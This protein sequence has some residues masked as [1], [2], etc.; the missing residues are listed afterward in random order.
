MPHAYNHTIESVHRLK[1]TDLE[2]DTQEICVRRAWTSVPFLDE[3][4]NLLGI[5][6][7]GDMP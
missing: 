5:T 7:T 4:E 6:L 3:Q 2:K 1:G